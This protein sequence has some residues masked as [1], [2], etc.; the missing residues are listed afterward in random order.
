MPAG[1]NP[2]LLAPIDFEK[3]FWANLRTEI[4]AQTPAL[5]AAEITVQCLERWKTDIVAWDAE[6]K[7]EA[8]AAK[9]AEAQ[10]AQQE[11]AEEEER[12]KAKEEREKERKKKF[13]EITDKFNGTN[14]LLPKPASIARTKLENMQFVELYRFTIA[15]C[16]EAQKQRLASN[17]TYTFEQT[18]T[19]LALQTQADAIAAK[20]V[21]PDRDLSWEQM[22]EG[23]FAMVRMTREV[24]WDQAYIDMFYEFYQLINTSPLRYIENGKRVLVLYQATMREE[25][26]N[27]YTTSKEA[28][29]LRIWND[30]LVEDI[31]ALV[32][33]EVAAEVLSAKVSALERSY[34]FTSLH[35]EVADLKAV[36]LGKRDRER[37]ENYHAN[38]NRQRQRPRRDFPQSTSR[39][40]QQR[41]SKYGSFSETFPSKATCAVC[42]G[43]H[44]HEV[45]KC[46]ANLLWSGEPAIV[47]RD[48]RGRIF[49]KSGQELCIDWQCRR[50]CS[51]KSKSHVHSCSGCGEDTHGAHNCPLAQKD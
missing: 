22:Q 32:R 35:K 24:N 6:A 37:G 16:K 48:S 5:A 45:R 27:H 20:T 36:L 1:E 50:G 4:L 18:D 13:V 25:W 12:V 49:N 9:A 21:I 46:Q 47:T 11:A 3:P 34:Q 10:R 8:D 31:R 44:K 30:A 40:Q 51:S 26:Y 7:A 33:D 19:G 14:L 29:D 43:S 38:D 17:T 23:L 15:G 28:F 39:G 41:K 2:R 42:L